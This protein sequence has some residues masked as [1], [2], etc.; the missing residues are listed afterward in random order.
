MGVIRCPYRGSLDPDGQCTYKEGHEGPHSY[1][2]GGKI[3]LKIGG[4]KTKTTVYFAGRKAYIIPSP[5]DSPRHNSPTLHI[6]Y[7][8]ERDE[9]VQKASVIVDL[10]ELEEA[11]KIYK[12]MN[13]A[14]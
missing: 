2:R 3:E 11:I 5:L 14:N 8:G 10:N 1:E 7:G 13:D 12:E 4:I 6:N 9:P